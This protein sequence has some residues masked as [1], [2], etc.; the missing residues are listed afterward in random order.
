MVFTFVIGPWMT[1]V[2]FILHIGI[3]LNYIWR[4]YSIAGK[5]RS[6]N[7]YELSE[8]R[9]YGFSRGLY[10]VVGV[11]LIDSG[12]KLMFGW[13]SYANWVLW[14]PSMFIF[15]ITGVEYVFRSLF[16][17]PNR[18]DLYVGVAMI[19]LTLFILEWWITAGEDFIKSMVLL[20]IPII[21][22]WLLLGPICWLRISFLERNGKSDKLDDHFKPIYDITDKY[23]RVFNKI[24]DVIIFAIIMVDLILRLEG[25]NILTIFM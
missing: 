11:V 24:T 22:S 18:Y 17:Y 3:L 23:E 12:I 4:D 6:E 14:L 20:L 9:R 8:K 16:R 25:Y 10:L 2:S 1:I 15:L 19:I 5:L 13:L 21:A 7:R